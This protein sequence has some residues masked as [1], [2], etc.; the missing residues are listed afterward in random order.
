MTAGPI[1]THRT[2][3]QSMRRVSLAWL[4]PALL[5]MAL[6]AAGCGSSNSGSSGSGSG[7]TTTGGAKVGEGKQGGAVTFLAA[8]DV[9]YLD[10]GQTYYTFGFMVHYAV[11]RTLYSFKPENSEKPVPDLAD[12]EPQINADNT[13][14]TVK[15][16]PGVK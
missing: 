12:G 11:N 14:I 16:K 6:V 7:S 1:S 3:G 13:E 9:D 5:A 4:V 10:P 2:E 8:G 15:I